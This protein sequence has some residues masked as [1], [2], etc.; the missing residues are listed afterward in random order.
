MKYHIEKNSVQETLVLPLYA[1][2][3]CS[4]LYPELF[5]D[6]DAAKLMER[7]DYDFSAQEKQSKSKMHVFGALEVAMRQTDLQTEVREY[8]AA[9]PNAAVV[10]LGC[11]LDTTGRTVDNGTCRIYNLDFPDVIAARDALLPAGDREK[12]IACDLNDLTWMDEID[13][14]EG[15]IFFAAGVFYY[16]RREQ[17]KAIFSAMAERFPGGRLVFDACGPFGVKLMLKTWVKQ[18]G[19]KDIGAYLAVKD[20][21]ELESWSP[22]LRASSKGYMLGYQRL[23]KDI[24]LLYRILARIGDHWIGMKIVRLDFSA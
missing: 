13:E 18:A 16:F 5:H 7:I 15:A 1:R 9:H 14:K 3:L 12:N 20:E 10:N 17:A 19:I 4:E 23:G 22:R 24:P 11:G 8:L 2:S 21:K 6:D